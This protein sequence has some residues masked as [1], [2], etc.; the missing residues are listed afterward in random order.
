MSVC[1]G[2][3]LDWIPECLQLSDLESV[4]IAVNI[5][6]LKI[7][8]LPISRWPAIKDKI[9]NVP[10]SDNDLLESLNTLNK[11]PRN[12]ADAGLIPVKLQRKLQYKNAVLE[13]YV[14]IDKLVA[15][16]EYL[17]KCGHPS[18]RHIEIGV[19]PVQELDILVAP[20][21]DHNEDNAVQE[22]LPSTDVRPST[23]TKQEQG[24][25]SGR[26]YFVKYQ[27]L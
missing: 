13:A 24:T 18:Y 8:A 1:N 25:N 23:S 9:V 12:A 5:L 6:F 21:N 2:L 17:K 11:L 19:P 22:D 27:Y 16:V 26:K 4:L 10:I 7:F 15:A 14:N 3:G 20:D